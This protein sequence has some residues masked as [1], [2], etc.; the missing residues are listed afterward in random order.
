MNRQ[1]SFTILTCLLLLTACS[2]Y[3]QPET[4]LPD[5]DWKQ[6]S[7]GLTYNEFKLRKKDLV[8][9]K[10]DPAKYEFSIVEN[11]SKNKKTIE[12]I[13]QESGAVVG[14]NGGFFTEDFAP[15]GLLISAGK[16]LNEWQK[17]DL[18]DGTFILDKNRT[19]SIL[20]NTKPESLENID[21]AIQSGPMLINNGAAVAK[22]KNGEAASRTVIG[23]DNQ[24]HI[25]LIILK[26]SILRLNNKVTLQEIVSLIQEEK[27][28]KELGI[29][30]LLNLDGGT[31]SGIFIDQKYFPEMEKVQHIILVH[32]T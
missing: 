23:I 31:S 14:F 2:T 4:A 10:I 11:D 21:F 24:N 9:V 32:Q 13:T 16:P 12:E 29:T 19:P 5:P 18:L 15:T 7:P 25:I 22:P 20:F 26:Q 30:N 8:I 1:V 28:L 6:I 27:E 3:T 17:A